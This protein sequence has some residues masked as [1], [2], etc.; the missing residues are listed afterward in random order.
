MLGQCPGVAWCG[1]VGWVRTRVSSGTPGRFFSAFPMVDFCRHVPPS[2]LNMLMV[3]L[4]L[5]L[6]AAPTPAG[7]VV[8]STHTRH[9]ISTVMGRETTSTAP[10]MASHLRLHQQSQS[11]RKGDEAERGKRIR[12]GGCRHSARHTRPLP[13]KT[14]SR[15]R[16]NPSHL[17]KARNAHATPPPKTPSKRRHQ[18]TKLH[19]VPAVGVDGALLPGVARGLTWLA[20]ASSARRVSVFTCPDSTGAA[21]VLPRDPFPSSDDGDAAFCEP[22]SGSRAPGESAASGSGADVGDGLEFLRSMPPLLL[23]L[24]PLLLPPLPPC[25]APN[26]GSGSGA[27][28]PCGA[29]VDGG[30]GAASGLPTM[31]T[32]PVGGSQLTAWVAL[33]R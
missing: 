6:D 27:M 7:A 33:L 20:N 9:S 18:T 30:A 24:P 29:L 8:N 21:A 2:L 11:T 23:P 32:Q 1:V 14:Q 10:Q 4:G 17:D 26:D 31:T 16:L 13:Q 19:H 15:I 25:R 3:I 22:S 28:V 5:S 12:G